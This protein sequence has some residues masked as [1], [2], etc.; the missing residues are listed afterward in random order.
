[1]INEELTPRTITSLLDQGLF[2]TFISTN[3]VFGG[4]RAWPN[5]DAPH[6]PQIPYAAQKSRAEEVVRV[7][8]KE[9]GA[10]DRLNIVRLTKILDPNTSPLPAWFS[11]WKKQEAVH[12]FSDLV[13]AP[14]SVQFVGEALATVGE[15][16]VSGNLHLSGAEN[17]SYVDLAMAL[18]ARLGINPS[19]IQPTSATAKGIHIAFKP[20][21]SGLGMERTTR[22]TGVCPQNL[23]AVVA[24]IA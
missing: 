9:T 17:I 19:L 10:E 13:F 3:S 15:K 20:R 24:D 4:E 18:A 8:A 6:D 1:V 5:E 22:L 14:M 2:V 7:S 23:E 11:A 16:R 21:F 12:P